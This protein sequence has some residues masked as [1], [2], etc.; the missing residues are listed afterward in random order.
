[1]QTILLAFISIVGGFVG[2]LVGVHMGR[3]R[4]GMT[5]RWQGWDA[6]IDFLLWIFKDKGN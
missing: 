5:D 1:M 3:R 4:Y 2:L 6:E